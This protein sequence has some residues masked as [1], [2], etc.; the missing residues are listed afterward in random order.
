MYRSV[1]HYWIKLRTRLTRC[2][3]TAWKMLF[4]MHK[5]F[6]AYKK[7][8]KMIVARDL[9]IQKQHNSIRGCCEKE[10][11]R[12]IKMVFF[13]LIS[14]VFAVG[15]AVWSGIYWQ[16][17]V[18]DRSLVTMI[19]YFGMPIGICVYSLFWLIFKSCTSFIFFVHAGTLFAAMAFLLMSH[20]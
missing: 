1:E 19:V 14:L 16:Q 11:Q 9:K 18:K 8:F 12:A 15:L 5:V 7:L 6:L 20:W 4:K 17:F 13:V 3:L 10:A 2:S